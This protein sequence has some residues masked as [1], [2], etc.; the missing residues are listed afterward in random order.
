M[1]LQRSRFQ[2]FADGRQILLG[3]REDHR[4]RLQLRDGEHTVLVGGVHDVARIDQA[5]AGA[6]RQRRADGGVGQLHPGALDRGLVGLDLGGQAGDGCRPLV[7]QL[8]RGVAVLGERRG[9][10]EILLGVGEAGLVLR[11]LG[12]RL[13]ES[14]LE[15]RRVDLH[16]EIALLDDLAFLEAD[17]LDLAVHARADGHDV[18]GLHRAEPVQG[19]RKR[20]AL[21]HPNVHRR[22][23]R[24]RLLSF[25]RGG[26]WRGGLMPDDEASGDCRDRHQRPAPSAKRE[27]TAWGLVHARPDPGDEARMPV[28]HDRRSTRAQLARADS[29]ELSA[30]L[31]DQGVTRLEND[32]RLR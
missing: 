28:R 11:Q 22:L 13:I 14:G 18:G 2:S 19:D 20:L 26:S 25:A 8:L 30:V 6:T 15:R 27:E 32:V 10:I 16:E 24:R 7:E 1:T 23:R 5:K 4:D 31:F 12:D 9:A 29:A 21:G 3:R 17:L